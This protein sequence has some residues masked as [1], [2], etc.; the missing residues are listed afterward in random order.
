MQSSLCRWWSS[1][2][3]RV[4][5]WEQLPTVMMQQCCHLYPQTTV[6]H[7]LCHTHIFKRSGFGETA[8]LFGEAEITGCTPS[9]QHVGKIKFKCRCWTGRS[10]CHDRRRQWLYATALL[11]TLTN[12]WRDLRNTCQARLL[13]NFRFRVVLLHIDCLL[14]HD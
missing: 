11:A 7:T 8:A 12:T 5:F 2:F 14:M 10:V 6:R 3:K 1:G 4:R 13:E 9:Q